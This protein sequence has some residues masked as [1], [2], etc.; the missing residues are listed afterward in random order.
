MHTKIYS[1]TVS[2][3]NAKLITVEIDLDD[4]SVRSEFSV[5]G[6]P[7]AGIKESRK[8][9]ITAL[10]NSGFR[11]PERRIIVNLS[12]ADL[13]KE[14]SLFDLPIAIGILHAIGAL[15]LSDKFINE[16]IIIGELSLDG[17]INPIKG[18]LAV[19]SDAHKFN[20]KRIILPKAN[21]FE[22]ALI[23]NVEVIGMSNLKD[24]FNILKIKPTVIDVD[25]FVQSQELQQLSFDDIKGQKYAKRAAQISAAGRHN[26]IFSGSPGSGKTMLAKRISSLMPRMEFSEILET[27]KIYSI[28]GRLAGRSLIA[29]RPFRAP[30]H[31]ASKASIIGGG[32]LNLLPGEISLAH[33]GILFLDEVPQFQKETLESLREPL[34]NKTINISR[35]K[36]AVE[37][38]TNA[39]LIAAYNPCPCGFFG[40][41]LKECRCNPSAIKSYQTKLSGPLLDRIDIRIGVKSLDYAEATQKVTDVGISNEELRSGVAR[42]TKAQRERFKDIKYNSDMNIHELEEFCVMSNEATDIIKKAFTRLNLS[43]RAYHKVLKLARTIADIDGFKAIEKQHITEAIMFKFEA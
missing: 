38:P 27:T 15:T 6:L 4:N 34:E 17:A 9:V 21:E 5:V 25:K 8:R 19:S 23:D 22:A 42:A 1:S 13:K 7:G 40:D 16:S 37:F 30:H 26:I 28:G 18:A 14:G 10:K 11:L 3:M 39:L 2:G 24:I 29:D 32:H 36:D 41:P 12:P 20:K 33:N 35:L 31:T 43:M